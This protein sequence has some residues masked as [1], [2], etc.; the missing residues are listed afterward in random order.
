M[1]L[2]FQNEIAQPKIYTSPDMYFFLK[3][4]QLCLHLALARQRYHVTNST[5]GIHT[6][7]T[8]KVLI[9]GNGHG[10]LKLKSIEIQ[11]ENPK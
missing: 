2:R 3:L 5:C 6:K 10:I 9:V 8:L 7:C 1:K 4:Q 11:K